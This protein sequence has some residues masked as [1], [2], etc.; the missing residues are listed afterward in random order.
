[1][2]LKETS[3]MMKNAIRQMH[4]RKT[5]SPTEAELSGRGHRARK[6]TMTP[7]AVSAYRALAHPGADGGGLQRRKKCEHAQT[8]RWMS[9][10]ASGRLVV[11]ADAAEGRTLRRPAN[12]GRTSAA[13]SS[14]SP[15]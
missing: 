1:M 3:A 10:A 4:R 2:A 6:V 9:A 12:R 8:R 13:D 11:A 5:T 7:P 15:G 14:R